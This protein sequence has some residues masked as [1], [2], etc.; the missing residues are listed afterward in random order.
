[1]RAAS[2][3]GGEERAFAALRMKALREYNQGGDI[4]HG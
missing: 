2:Q 1:M 4:E 3:E